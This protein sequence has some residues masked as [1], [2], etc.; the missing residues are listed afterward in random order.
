MS[1]QWTLFDIAQSA[2]KI[3]DPKRSKRSTRYAF[4]IKGRTVRT[5]QTWLPLYLTLA[6]SGL[7]FFRNPLRTRKIEGSRGLSE[8][9]TTLLSIVV[10]ASQPPCACEGRL[11]TVLV[12]S[13][14]RPVGDG[15]EC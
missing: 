15:P 4:A 14:G 7:G 12:S 10:L 13:K 5:E 1:H 6:R 8:N 2:K 11:R 3:I 9:S